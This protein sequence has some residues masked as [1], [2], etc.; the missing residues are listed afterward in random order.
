M[1]ESPPFSQSGV[2]A[3]IPVIDEVTAVGPLVAGLRKEG[4]CCV[5]VVDGGSTDGTQHAA[6]A[7]GANVIDEARRGSGRA[8]LTGASAAT[9]SS[10]PHEVIVFL[11]GDGSCDPC[12]VPALVGPL[13][14]EGN[15]VHAVLGVRHRRLVAPGALPWHARLG[16]ALVA[17]VLAL[18]TGRHP[19]DLSPYKAIRVGALRALALD[20][21]HYAWTVQFVARVLRRP[22]LLIARC[23]IRFRRRAGGVS[24]VSGSLL[25]SLRAGRQM[26]SAAVAETRRRPA[27]VLMA[28][29][30]EPGS[31][32][33]RLAS[34]IG[35]EAA[36]DFWRA[37]LGDLG[38][39]LGRLAARAGVDLLVVVPSRDA[40]GPVLDLVGPEWRP[41]VQSAP[42][43]ANAL[44][45]TVEVAARGGAPAVIAISGDNPTLPDAQ[46]E[47]ALLS[48]RRRRRAVIGPTLDGGYHLVGMTLS[49]WPPPFGRLRRQS[50]TLQLERVFPA[51]AMGTATSLDV[52]SQGL[53]A[54][55]YSLLR[56]PSWPDVDT[57]DDLRDLGRSFG[58]RADAPRTAAWL[59]D[60]AVELAG[61]PGL[62]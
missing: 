39:R 58:A 9:G 1:T 56:L 33:T 61:R 17:A 29:A 2:A 15:E 32:K 25:V 20:E 40:V 31:V 49:R 42:G 16:N 48:V 14:G 44:R 43:L 54:A 57:V 8:C 38:E 10:H 4:V 50:M 53:L 55:G 19:G 26:L 36:T 59:R 45:E 47:R 30:P 24:K 11:D 3:V 13:L 52:A 41:V 22:D 6:A 37:C 35:D 5:F 34:V 7:E 27:L 21:E 60:H 12:D 46:I 18:R 28:K 23:P 51:S 62:T